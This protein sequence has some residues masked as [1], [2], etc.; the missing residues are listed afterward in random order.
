MSQNEVFSWI[1][2]ISGSSLLISFILLLMFLL[3]KFL[4]N[5]KQKN[6]VKR[7]LSSNDFSQIIGTKK[8]LKIKLRKYF[9]E[10]FIR[11]VDI[12]LF[13]KFLKSES[14]INKKPTKIAWNFFIILTSSI[15]VNKSEGRVSEAIKSIKNTFDESKQLLLTSDNNNLVTDVIL[16]IMNLKIRPILIASRSLTKIDTN[17]NFIIN[18]ENLSKEEIEDFW[19]QIDKVRKDLIENK[20]LYFI[21]ILSL[22]T[23]TNEQLKKLLNYTNQYKIHKKEAL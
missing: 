21:S 17:C 5:Y 13:K 4:L 2:V 6:K 16:K 11:D 9:K 7:I 12:N 14:G 18:D 1:G 15:L 3:I 19:K 22:S 23:A 20:Y 10:I 8:E